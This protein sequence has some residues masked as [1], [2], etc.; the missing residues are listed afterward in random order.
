[1][2]FA[3]AGLW[4]LTATLGTADVR[5]VAAGIYDYELI[6]DE[7]TSP[8]AQAKPSGLTFDSFAPA[9]FLVKAK[10]NLSCGPP[11]GRSEIALY[12]WLPGGHVKLLSNLEQLRF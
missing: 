8:T 12:L 7:F 11:C 9:P 5:S 4:V 3:Y 1:M 6:S 10:F 2:L